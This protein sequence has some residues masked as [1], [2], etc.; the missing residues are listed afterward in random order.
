LFWIGQK[1]PFDACAMKYATAISPLAMNAAMPVKSPT[2]MSAPH[3][4][5][6]MPEI[7]A[8]HE[9][10]GTVPGFPDDGMPSSFCVP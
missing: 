7:P 1:P 3:T 5:S 6:M 4:S 2:T 8:G 10:G 9:N